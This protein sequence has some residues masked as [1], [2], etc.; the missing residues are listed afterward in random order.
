MGRILNLSTRNRSK[1]WFV[2]LLRG[3]KHAVLNDCVYRTRH[4]VISLSPAQVKEIRVGGDAIM[5]PNCPAQSSTKQ[6]NVER[7][8]TRMPMNTFCVSILTF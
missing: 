4:G 8:T 5:R 7:V 3:L 1:L 6:K 2:H